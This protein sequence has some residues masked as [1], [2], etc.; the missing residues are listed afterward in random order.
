MYTPKICRLSVNLHLSDFIISKIV[1]RY[2]MQSTRQKF[3]R[4]SKLD[5]EEF[6]PSHPRYP[7]YGTCSDP[8]CSDHARSMDIRPGVMFQT[9]RHLVTGLLIRKIVLVSSFISYFII[10]HHIFTRSLGLST[11][12]LLAPVEGTGA[13]GGSFGGL[14]PPFLE[15]VLQMCVSECV[16]HKFY[17]QLAVPV[18][19]REYWVFF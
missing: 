13:L 14:W 5:F 3:C 18:V 10:F 11:P 15:A 2:M 17:I 9:S 19:G 12:L 7:R 1:Y 4:L 6:Y 16:G 8:T